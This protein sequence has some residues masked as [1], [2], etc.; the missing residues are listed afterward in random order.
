M[1]GD[2][3]CEEHSC[4]GLKF[5]TW[6]PEE[7]QGKPWKRMDDEKKLKEDI[8]SVIALIDYELLPWWKKFWL[9]IHK[10]AKFHSAS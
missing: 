8:R 7:C 4:E 1:K 2:K 3:E 9:K 5:C 10:R 6:H